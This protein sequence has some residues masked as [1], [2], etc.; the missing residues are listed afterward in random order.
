LIKNGEELVADLRPEDLPFPGFGRE[1]ILD[2][3]K[4]EDVNSKTP[5]YCKDFG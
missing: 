3:A 1:D 5:R 2:L 4:L